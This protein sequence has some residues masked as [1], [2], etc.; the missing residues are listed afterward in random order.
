LGEILGKL[1]FEPFKMKYSGVVCNN[2]S[3]Y[4][5]LDEETD[6]LMKLFAEK[7]E[8]L[9]QQNGIPVHWPRSRQQPVGYPRFSNFIVSV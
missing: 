1:K 2:N 4:A 8:T 5:V 6:K 7:I 9:M 3:I